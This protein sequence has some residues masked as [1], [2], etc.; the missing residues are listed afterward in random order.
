MPGVFVSQKKDALLV[1]VE[2]LGVV[3]DPIPSRFLAVQIRVYAWP[4]SIVFR[5]EDGC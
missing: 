3:V 4:I 5:V 2:I 1:P